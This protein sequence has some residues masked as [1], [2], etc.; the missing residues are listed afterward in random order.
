MLSAVCLNFD[1]SKI[2]SSCNGLSKQ[3]N[4]K[5]VQIEAFAEDK[6]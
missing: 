3:G 2:L 1:Q 4:I 6:I 5:P